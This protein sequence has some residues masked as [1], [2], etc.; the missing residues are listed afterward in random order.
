MILANQ[1]LI[2][3]RLAELNPKGGGTEYDVE[4][5]RSCRTAVE[6]GYEWAYESLIPRIAEKTMSEEQSREV[7]DILSMFE[8]MEKAWDGSDDKR[9][10]PEHM[11]RFGGWDG[12]NEGDQ[13]GFAAFFCEGGRRFQ[14][15]GERAYANAHMPTL[16]RYRPMLD[17]F[18]K[19]PQQY[20]LSMDDVEKIQN[21]W[22]DRREELDREDQGR[23]P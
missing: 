13:M 22:H 19:L 7:L 18:R 15:L 10:I 23:R 20:E 14:S 11:I 2:L 5:L 6:E 12:N 8:W 4:G 1:Y 9:N 17:A 3:E 16:Q 21:A